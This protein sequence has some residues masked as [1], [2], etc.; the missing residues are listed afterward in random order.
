M[1]LTK[2]QEMFCQEVVKQPTYSA[3]YRIAYNSSG[4]NDDVINVEASKLMADPK[5]AIRVNELKKKVENKMLYTLEKSIKRDL[6]LI[7]RYEAA[8]DVLENKDAEGKDVEVAERVIR[9]IT[10]SG[11]SNAQDRISKQSGYFEK[12]N[13]QKHPKDDMDWSK[14]N[15]EDLITMS[16]IRKKAQM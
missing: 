16:R 1:G 12:N 3:A 6:S 15:D 2:K 5:I 9:F 4:M 8:L 7:E 11:Y 13:E 10:H 14:L